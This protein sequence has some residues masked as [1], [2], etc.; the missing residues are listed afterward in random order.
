MIVT[1]VEYI[2][3]YCGLVICDLWKA[4]RNDATEV[5]EEYPIRRMIPHLSRE[6]SQAPGIGAEPIVPLNLLFLRSNKS[7]LLE[8]KCD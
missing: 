4:T 7:T 6:E 8:I 3:E 5:L 2:I 1:K